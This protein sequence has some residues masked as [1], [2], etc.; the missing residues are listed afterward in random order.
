MTKRKRLVEVGDYVKRKK[1]GKIMRV[2]KDEEA[3]LY[4]DNDR[5]GVTDANFYL[6]HGAIEKV[7]NE[8]IEKV[9]KYIKYI[10]ENVEMLNNALDDALRVKEIE[11]QNKLYR[12]AL[13][14]YADRE[15]YEPE[16]YDPD[17][18][19][20]TSMIDHDKGAT[21]RKALEGEGK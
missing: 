7:N 19:D 13:E 8:Q 21:A 5:I 1:D 20:Y 4:V 11:Q 15:N 2:T 16:H 18:H 9:V 17:T 12:E 6:E 14:F 3:T 10:I